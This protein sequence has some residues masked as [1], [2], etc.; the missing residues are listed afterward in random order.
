MDF[1]DAVDTFIQ[2]GNVDNYNGDNAAVKSKK[3]TEQG[4]LKFIDLNL[5]LP[6]GTYVQSAQLRTLTKNNSPGIVY[7]YRMI[8]SWGDT[9][10]WNSLGSGVSLDNVDASS[11]WSFRVFPAIVNQLEITDVTSDV[12]TWISNPSS[13]QGWI[14]MNDSTGKSCRFM[15]SF[16]IVLRLIM[17]FVLVQMIGNSLALTEM[18]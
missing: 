5:Y 10:T 18:M 13:N 8:Q 1:Y 17:I 11:T 3:D 4:L 15:A 14:F 2:P 9:S 7:G 12:S 6:S 16:I